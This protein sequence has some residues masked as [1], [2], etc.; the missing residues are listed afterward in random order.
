MH[1]SEVKT[2]GSVTCVVPLLLLLRRI[3]FLLLLDSKQRVRMKL[4]SAGEGS[5]TYSSVAFIRPSLLLLLLLL[6]LL[7]QKS[8]V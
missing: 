4:K 7:K 8:F 2:N 6:H 5:R 1:Q 3:L